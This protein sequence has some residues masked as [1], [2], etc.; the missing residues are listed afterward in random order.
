M[1]VQQLAK[2]QSTA[3]A[4]VPAETAMGTGSMTIE[5]GSWSGNAFTAGSGTPVSVTIAAGEDS[6]AEIAA[7]INDADAGVSATVLKDAS[8]ERLL[9]R[10]K[11]TGATNGFRISDA[12]D[13]GTNA[14]GR[15]SAL[16]ISD[17]V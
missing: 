7:K 14:D 13:D 3:S 17:Y 2:A 12:D 1:A 5:L 16:K 4:A 8:G 6:L 10:S 9:M 15:E 11:D